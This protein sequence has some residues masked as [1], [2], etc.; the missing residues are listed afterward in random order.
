MQKSKKTSESKPTAFKHWINRDLLVRMA[1]AIQC[2][3][4]RFDVKRFV[5][6]AEELEGLELK[7]RVRRVRDQ[8]IAQLPK[9]FPRALAVLMKSI[10]AGTL[11]GFDLW[12]YA[13]WLQVQGL[14]DLE[15][16]LAAMQ[17]LTKRFTSEFAVRPFLLRHPARTLT[18]LE[19]CARSE[20]EHVRRWASEGS[21]PRLP[22][23]ERLHFLVRDP[24]P[25]LK[26]L[27]LLKFDP[28]LYVRKSVA[29]HLND[30]SKDHPALVIATLK[31]WKREAALASDEAL[32]R[33]TWVIHRALRSEIKAGNAAALALIGA[34]K[35]RSIRVQSIR[36]KPI[37][38][39]VGERLEFSFEVVSRHPAPQKIVVD[40]R[41]HFM[42]ARGRWSPKV[43]K[44]KTIELP[45]RQPVLIKKAHSLKP[46]TTRKYYSGKHRIEFQVNGVCMGKADWRLMA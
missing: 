38:A 28:A 18:Y 3:D 27:E 45:P 33:V 7:P 10:E 43:F 15:A 17:E 35:A 24:G 42:T 1:H 30:I 32:A 31:R 20:D 23:G 29:N 36:L 41:I 2:V 46:I 37:T 44:L 25:T 16:S 21:R 14:N 9:E 22:W 19:Q 39:R 6:V 34:K 5:S 12:P 26:I 4:A 13:E 11:K 8:L 40:Y